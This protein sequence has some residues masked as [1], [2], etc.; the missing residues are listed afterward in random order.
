MSSDQPRRSRVTR[1]LRLTY[2]DVAAE[3]I[4]EKFQVLLRR[5][6]DDDLDPGIGAVQPRR[7][8]GGP[9]SSGAAEFAHPLAPRN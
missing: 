7:P 4:P 5:L 3:P 9:K 2:E 6:D 1:N 8:R